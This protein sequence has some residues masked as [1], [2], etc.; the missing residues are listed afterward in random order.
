MARG[1]LLVVTLVLAGVLAAP[2]STPA[3]SAGGPALT[4]TDGR[5]TAR[6][7]AVPFRQVMEELSRITGVAI[8]ST[9]ED[10]AQLIS[11]TFDDLALDEAIRRIVRDDFALAT[12]EGGDL[13]IWLFPRTSADGIHAP[14][15]QDDAKLL[16]P[17]LLVSSRLEAVGLLAAHAGRDPVA[18]A[19]LTGLLEGDADPVVRERARRALEAMP[20]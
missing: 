17:G 4:L 2:A 16:L 18:K 10:G 11:V 13:E 1:V 12:G 14:P 19:L 6:V 3:A 8:R 20:P 15:P 5:L 9:G 7:M